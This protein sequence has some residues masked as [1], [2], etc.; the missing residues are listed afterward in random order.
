[1]FLSMTR[2]A[3]VFALLLSSL[4]NCFSQSKPRDFYLGIDLVRSLPTYFDQGFTFEPS[5]VYGIKNG[6]TLDAAFGI[7]DISKNEIFENIKYN[8]AGNYIRLGVRKELGNQTNFDVGLAVGYSYYKETGKT[9]FVGKYFGD[10]TYE[11]STNDKIFFIEPSVDYKFQLLPKLFLIP[12]LRVPVPLTAFEKK[13]F[14]S[15]SA[16]GI[17]YLIPSPEFFFQRIAVRLLYKIH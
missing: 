1:M 16:P 13:S 8:C 9:T 14:K 7:S 12:Q 10:Y 6:F 2:L 5:L 11:E 15:Y 17:G 4:S 3:L